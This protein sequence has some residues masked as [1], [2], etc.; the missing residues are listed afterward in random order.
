MPTSGLINVMI[1]HILRIFH[2][3]TSNPLIE[4]PGQQPDAKSMC[5]E[6]KYLVRCSSPVPA[7]SLIIVISQLFSTDDTGCNRKKKQTLNCPRIFFTGFA[8][9]L[10]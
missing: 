6:P 3:Y 1:A 4:V 2:A 9:S 5:T 8:W 7:G 10:H